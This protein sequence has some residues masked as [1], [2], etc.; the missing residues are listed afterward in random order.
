MYS[1]F[2]LIMYVLISNNYYKN[3]Q[4]VIT[5]KIINNVYVYLKKFVSRLSVFWIFHLKTDG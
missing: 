5:Q 3:M 2:K 1:K 4:I